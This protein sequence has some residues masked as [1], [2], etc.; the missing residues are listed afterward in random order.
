MKKVKENEYMQ[1]ADTSAIDVLRRRD[2]AVDLKNRAKRLREKYRAISAMPS[3]H[4]MVYMVATVAH[5]SAAILA[6]LNIAPILFGLEVELDATAT[7]SDFGQI[8]LPISMIFFLT[9]GIG[10]LI[11][12]IQFERDEI[13]PK[14]FVYQHLYLWTSLIVVVIY[15]ALVYHIVNLGIEQAGSA[16]KARVS[17][18][19]TLSLAEIVIAVFAHKGW[20]ILSFRYRTWRYRVKLRRNKKKMLFAQQKCDR[21]Y[22]YYLQ[23]A[24]PEDLYLT[25]NVEQVLL[26]ELLDR[27]QRA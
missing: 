19:L 16:E 2:K 10:L 15:F 4:Q 11:S 23:A 18:I 25:S 6:G 17:F 14:S 20:T 12:K 27:K 21:Y 8:L 1:V 26:H 22:Q 9:L 13:A 5:L 7:W 3:G 24:K